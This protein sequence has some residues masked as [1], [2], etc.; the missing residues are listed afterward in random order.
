MENLGFCPGGKGGEIVGAGGIDRNGRAVEGDGVEGSDQVNAESGDGCWAGS[1]KGYS[2]KVLVENLKFCLE[3]KGSIFGT[4]GIGE[5]L[6]GR[7]G[8]ILLHHSGMITTARTT[9]TRG[10]SSVP[11]I[12]GRRKLWNCSWISCTHTP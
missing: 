3:G 12:V 8:C 6:G 4:G 5:E 11:S 7:V 1:S 2:G 9:R 10:T